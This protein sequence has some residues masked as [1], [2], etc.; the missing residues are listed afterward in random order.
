MK[1]VLTMYAYHV[2]REELVMICA[3]RLRGTHVSLRFV[4]TQ[5]GPGPRHRKK[6]QFRAWLSAA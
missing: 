1:H 5:G 3:S 6:G 2:L 4:E